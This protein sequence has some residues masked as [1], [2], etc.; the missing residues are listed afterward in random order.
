MLRKFYLVFC[1]HELKG[2]FLCSYIIKVS[3]IRTSY[4]NIKTLISSN[5]T[6]NL[7]EKAKKAVTTFFDVLTKFSFLF[8]KERSGKRTGSNES[9]MAHP[10]QRAIF[11]LREI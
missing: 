7:L 11:D 3:T 2:I 4:Q 5:K 6:S 1:V 10:Y 9:L 8:L